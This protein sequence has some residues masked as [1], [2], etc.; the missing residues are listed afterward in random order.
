MN[1]RVTKDA[2]KDAARIIDEALGFLYP[3]AL[4]VAA[5]VGVA[6]H[7]TDGPRT[8]SELAKATGTDPR[9]LHRVLRL[10]AT[11]GLFEED[12][13]GRFRLTETGDALRSDAP[14][15]VRSAVL[16]ITDRTFW[17]PAGEMTRCVE[18]GASAFEDIFGAPFFDHFERDAETAA[19]FHDGMASMSDAENQP[20]ADAY[21]FPPGATVVDVGGG[22]GGLLLSVLSDRPDLQGTLYDQPHVLAGHRLN[23]PEL[24]GRWTTAEGDFFTSAPPGDIYLL[25]RI[26][27]DWDDAQ[28]RTILRNCREAMRPGGRVLVIDAVIPQG[29][30]PHQGKTLDLMMMASLVGRERTE[31]EFRDLF[32]EAGLHL[33]R[34]IPT[35]TVLSIVEGEAAMD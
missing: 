7:L 4:R 17:L 2:R 8:P 22:H 16:M 9:S 25:K 26:L 18:Q 19:I 29:N 11:R 12:G 35:G 3:A 27:H 6:D 15:S 31:R 34:I 23:T 20:I 5:A 14:L 21:S 33:S 13:E 10:L 28:S 24:A 32:A 1:H 30:A